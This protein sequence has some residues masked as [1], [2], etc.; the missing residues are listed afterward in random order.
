M[1]RR[2]DD[3][4]VVVVFLQQCLTSEQRKADAAGQKAE[5]RDKKVGA[6]KGCMTTMDAYFPQFKVL[7]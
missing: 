5:R 3:E 4:R 6:T 2:D 1:F 7:T